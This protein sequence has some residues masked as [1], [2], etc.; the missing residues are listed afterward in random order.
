M[1]SH[2]SMLRLNIHNSECHSVTRTSGLDQLAPIQGRASKLM[3]PCIVLLALL[4]VCSAST[5]LSY[6]NAS[7]D[8]S[9]AIA[10]Q[11]GTTQGSADNRSAENLV[12]ASVQSGS[13]ADAQINRAITSMARR[14][15]IVWADYSANQTWAT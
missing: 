14:N 8:H 10:A 6:A 1:A 7:S 15:G 5:P 3:K 12:K 2:D 9:I 4:I 11:A 13:T